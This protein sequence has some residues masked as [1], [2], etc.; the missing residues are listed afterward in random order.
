MTL[1]YWARTTS[2]LANR[3]YRNVVYPPSF[4]YDFLHER[5]PTGKLCF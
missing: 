1:N 5:A 3:V 2:L 4:R